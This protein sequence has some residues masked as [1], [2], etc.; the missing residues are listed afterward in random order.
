MISVQLIRGQN[1]GW[2]DYISRIVQFQLYRDLSEA[3]IKIPI[4]ERV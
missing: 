3:I 1:P 4:N 2:L